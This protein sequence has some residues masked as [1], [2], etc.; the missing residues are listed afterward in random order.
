MHDVGI[1]A[2]LDKILYDQEITQHHSILRHNMEPITSFEPIKSHEIICS[3]SQDIQTCCHDNHDCT[4][5]Y[6]TVIKKK[7]QIIH[8]YIRAKLFLFHTWSTLKAISFWMAVIARFAAESCACS[9]PF[10]VSNSS[11][12]FIF[13]SSRLL[14]FSFS[15]SL[16]SNLSM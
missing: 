2:V 16:S 14:T 15:P 11:S 8:V 10:T 12:S 13:T 3:S 6:F 1:H 9:L 7:I 4:S 5:Q